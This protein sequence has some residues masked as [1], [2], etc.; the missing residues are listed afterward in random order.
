M[1]VADLDHADAPDRKRLS[2]FEDIDVSPAENPLDGAVTVCNMGVDELDVETAHRVVE[3]FV[4]LAQLC[5][6]LLGDAESDV[7]VDPIRREGRY[8]F[9]RIGRVP[10]VNPILCDGGLPSS[11][12]VTEKSTGDADYNKIPI[13]LVIFGFPKFRVVDVA[14]NCQE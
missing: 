2:C 3:E 5:A 9:F 11:P 14:S 13:V 1:P 4:Q 6:A 8:K 12:R 7:L 10:A